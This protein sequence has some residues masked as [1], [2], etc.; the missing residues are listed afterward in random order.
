MSLFLWALLLLCLLVLYSF[1]RRYIGGGVCTCNTNML[2][3]VVAITGAT[4]GIGYETALRIAGC[5]A[6]VVLFDRNL[7][8][9]REVAEEI[10]RKTTNQN[11]SSIECDLADLT[12]VA[13]AAKHFLSL[14][15]AC[16]VLI[17]NAGIM[18]CPLM[19]TPQGFEMQYG[20]NHLGHFA[21]T[22]KLLPA[23]RAGR[24]RIINVSSRLHFNAPK[25][26]IDFDFLRHDNLLIAGPGHKYSPFYSYGQSKLANVLF[27]R[28]LQNRF[29]EHGITA[30]AVHPGIVKTRL[31]RHTP[32]VWA[33]L[34]LVSKTASQGAQTQVHLAL[35]ELSSLKPGGYYADCEPSL[36]SKASS[37]QALAAQ[38]WDTSMK[39]FEA[40]CK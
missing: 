3:K 35:A 25:V 31:N 22:I 19:K 37:D 11:V 15:E 40:Y 6:T 24:A 4:S 17:N 26:G 18:M 39:H 34:N 36:A 1:Y 14:H 5:G 20:T 28:E 16:H 2:G 12:C 23:L 38:L 8:K 10:K 29:S 32:P 7:Q 27:T 13:N 33:L 21:L 30:F 9:S